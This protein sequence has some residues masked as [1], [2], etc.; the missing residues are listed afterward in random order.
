MCESRQRVTIFTR[1]DQT[2]RRRKISADQRD[3]VGRR[4]FLK[5]RRPANQKKL[6]S[7]IEG[8]IPDAILKVER[9]RCP[10][11]VSQIACGR[12]G[13]SP[14]RPRRRSARSWLPGWRTG[15]KT[16]WRCHEA[17][18]RTEPWPK[19]LWQEP[20]WSA[21]RRARLMRAR[22]ATTQAGGNAWMS[23]ADIAWMR[24][25]ALRLPFICWEAFFLPCKKLG[26]EQKP[27][28]ENGK[29]CPQ[30]RRYEASTMDRGTFR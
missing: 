26:R 28:R 2:E 4:N 23:R 24:R 22:A 6:S 13:N 11:A 19:G 20:R 1:R 5:L 25:S 30:E 21:G 10:P 17:R 3:G 18:D 16:R 14:G 29:P 27:R 12:F 15:L 7:L 8:H 9:A